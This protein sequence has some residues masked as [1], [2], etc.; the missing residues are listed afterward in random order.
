MKSS[1]TSSE[2]D[3]IG[4]EDHF[5]GDSTDDVFVYEGVG[6]GDELDDLDGIPQKTDDSGTIVNV[7]LSTQSVLTGK[8]RW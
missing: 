5:G 8:A 3:G 6:V 4:G 7:A 1:P 2:D